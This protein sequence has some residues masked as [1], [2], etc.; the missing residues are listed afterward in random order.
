MMSLR[1]QAQPPTCLG[2]DGGDEG[3]SEAGTWT[4]PGSRSSCEALWRR[5]EHLLVHARA[6]IADHEAAQPMASVDGDRR[7]AMDGGVVE[8]VVDELLK[9][10][11]VTPR[12]ELWR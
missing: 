3:Q 9:S 12:L 8:Q 4:A 7:K 10:R 6:A 11:R 5:R 2:D 1:V